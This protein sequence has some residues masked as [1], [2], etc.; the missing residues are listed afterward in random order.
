MSLNWSPQGKPLVLKIAFK[1]PQQFSK[2]KIPVWKIR[3]PFTSTGGTSKSVSRHTLLDHLFKLVYCTLKAT[4]EEDLSP[5]A[6]IHFISA[7]MFLFKQ[8]TWISIFR[9]CQY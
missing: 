1:H 2:E 9:F 5:T 6:F 4:T 8:L 3:L 7:L